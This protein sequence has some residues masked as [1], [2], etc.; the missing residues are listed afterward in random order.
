MTALNKPDDFILAI[1]VLDDEAAKLRYVRQPYNVK[2]NLASLAS[3]TT[4]RYF[5]RGQSRSNE[6][7]AH[8]Y[9]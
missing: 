6:L 4:S 8:Y 9:V 5:W 1:V 7:R 3:T 2:Q